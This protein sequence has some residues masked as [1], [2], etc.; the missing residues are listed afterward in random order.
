VDKVANKPFPDA[1]ILH[2]TGSGAL[3]QVAAHNKE[4]FI[5]MSLGIEGDPSTF[6][7]VRASDVVMVHTAHDDTIVG[8]FTLRVPVSDSRSSR[9]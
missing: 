4:R 2:A 9:A 3:V 7:T 6:K 1:V 5:G 8:G